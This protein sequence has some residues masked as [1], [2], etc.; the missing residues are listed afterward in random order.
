MWLTSKQFREKYNIS[1][2][3]L[4]LLKKTNKVQTKPYIGS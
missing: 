4:Y 2:Q 1:P 3:Y